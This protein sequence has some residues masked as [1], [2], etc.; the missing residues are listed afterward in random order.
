M[1]ALEDSKLKWTDS[2]GD[3]MKLA[4]VEE[5]MVYEQFVDFI[6]KKKQVAILDQMN[7]LVDA[8][9]AKKKAKK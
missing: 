1:L 2:D 4:D 3:I 5:D 7:K 9:L 6:E 8:K